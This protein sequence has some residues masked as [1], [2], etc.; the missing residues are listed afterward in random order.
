MQFI[1]Y[2]L[3]GGFAPALIWLWFWL[4][5]DPHPEPKRAIFF[6]FFAG[7]LAVPIALLLEESASKAAISLGL[8]KKGSIGVSM[9]IV[10]AAI[11]EYLKYFAAKQIA[12]KRKNF[13]EPVDALIYMITA[14]LGFAAFENTL[15]LFK[16]FQGH[17]LLLGFITGNLRFLGATVLHTVA[18]GTLGASIGFGFFHKEHLRRNIFGGFILAV[19][20]HVFFNLFIIKSSGSQIL[21]TF[22]LIW[23]AAVAIIFIFE[24]IKRIKR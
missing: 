18:S 5:E 6:T 2:A 23:V 19:L 14:A 7:A 9:L 3:I 11:E 17:G 1:I 15:F 24:K 21:Q 13:D 8:A 16:V 4:K 10:W 12:L 20:L 22:A